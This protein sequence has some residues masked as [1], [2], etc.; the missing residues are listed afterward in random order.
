MLPNAALALPCRLSVF[1]ESASEL[2]TTLLAD[3]VFCPNASTSLAR[4]LRS[5]L[6]FD[7]YVSMASPTVSIQAEKFASFTLASP[8]FEPVRSK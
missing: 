5:P 3:A 8:P 7:P 1:V 2:V 4:L 6:M